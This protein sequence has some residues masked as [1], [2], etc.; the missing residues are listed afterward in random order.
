MK[1]TYYRVTLRVRNEPGVLARITTRIRKFQI[2]IRSLDV[3]PIDND[4]KF[5]DIHMTLETERCDITI[6]M[7]KL[8]SLVPVIKTGY[9]KQGNL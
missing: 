4:E 2:N 7:N 6:I 1:K 9:E 5:S 3:A 8:A